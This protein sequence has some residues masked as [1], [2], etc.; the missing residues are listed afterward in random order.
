[1]DQEQ[2]T[3]RTIRGIKKALERAG[4]EIAYQEP[5]LT[6][7]E[8]SDAEVIRSMR[9]FDPRVIITIGSY[10]TAKMANAFTGKPIIFA[11]VMNPQASG[12]VRSLQ[13]PKGNITGAALDI[14]PDI[15]FNYLRRVITKVKR[16]G[17]LY[18]P[19]TENIV[20]Q[21]EIAAKTL[22]IKLVAL[23]VLTE[24]DVPQAIDSICKVADALWSVADPIVYGP[25][26]TRHIILQTLR[27][28]I[29][30]MGFSQAFVEA[31]ALFTLDFD[32]KD[33][34]RQ[35]GEIAVRVLQGTPPGQIPVSTPGVLYFNYNE[36]TASQISIKIPDDLLA[37][38]KEV[39]K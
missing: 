7:Q 33:I 8:T 4:S 24:R 6:G 20:R 12:F 27:S 3:Q 14:P 18:S 37:V 26:S 11:T 5:L 30:L 34:G 39:I 19:E 32:F 31:G 17:V 35:A 2:S 10:A 9:A 36:K 25:Q 28:R 1:M 15:Q 16:L 38:A 13:E 21:A 29:P 23:K 22:G